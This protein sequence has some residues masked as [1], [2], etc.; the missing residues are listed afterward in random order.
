MK[1]GLLFFLLFTCIAPVTKAQHTAEQKVIIEHQV[2]ERLGELMKMVERKHYEGFGKMMAY[3]GRDP[4]RA[5]QD[6]LNLYDPHEKLFAE[7]SLNQLA[8]HLDKSALWHADNFRIV[9]G[10]ESEMYIFDMEFTYLKGKTKKYKVTFLKLEDEILFC[11]A[12]K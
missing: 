5:M 12:D 2:R 10:L 9:Q 3:T 7:L 11:H 6:K 8:H 1:Y 4:N